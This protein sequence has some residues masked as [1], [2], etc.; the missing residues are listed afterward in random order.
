MFD[1]KT[2]FMY[3]LIIVIIQ[4]L[5]KKNYLSK[6]PMGLNYNI[7][8]GKGNIEEYLDTIN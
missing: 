7:L 4:Q 6:I 3:H 5:L 1:L 8:F 2:V